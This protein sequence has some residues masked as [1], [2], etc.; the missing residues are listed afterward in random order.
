MVAAS[1]PALRAFESSSS[2]VALV[3]ICL[4]WQR[5]RS[6]PPRTAANVYIR[7][8]GVITARASG[9]LYRWDRVDGAG[10]G[11]AADVSI[12]HGV[13][14]PDSRCKDPAPMRRGSVA[15]LC[16]GTLSCPHRGKRIA[17]KIRKACARQNRNHRSYALTRDALS[18]QS[19]HAQVPAGRSSQ[20]TA[21]PQL[22]LTTDATA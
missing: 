18:P 16:K 22:D 8:G 17:T 12:C 14:V 10:W 5:V 13:L 4:P 2:V 20:R 15:D 21:I 6:P 19:R 3:H 1:F 11:R 7:D 9:V